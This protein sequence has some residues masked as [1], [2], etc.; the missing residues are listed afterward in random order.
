MKE[1]LY[2]PFLQWEVTSECNH[3]CIHCYNYWRK[4]SE[5]NHDIGDHLS[6][7]KK[8]VE[9]HPVSVVITGGEPLLVFDSIKSSLKLL[10]E[11]GI[12]LSI[13][14]NAVLV[15]DEIAEFLS[16]M[17]VS[18]LVS[19]PCSVPS[20]C[21]EI[22]N[23]PGSLDRIAKG[24]KILLK[25]NIKV[26]VNMVVSKKNVKYIYDTAKY[27]KEVLGISR[28]F[29]SRV[30]KPINSDKEFIKELLSKEEVIFIY[31]ELIRISKELKLTTDSSTPMPA[32][33]AMNEEIFNRFAYSRNCS[34]GKTS[35]GLDCLGNIKA[36]PR[37]I[38]IYG[39]ILTDDFSEVWSKMAEWR[40][41]KFVPKECK[42]CNVKNLCNGGCRL[43]AFPITGRRDSLDPLVCLE[44][45]PIKFTKKGTKKDFP[46][47]QVFIIPEN[48]QFI[49]EKFG[50]RVSV[51]RGFLVITDEMK[52]FLSSCTK[53]CI[54]DFIN[55]FDVEY[56]L[57]NNAVNLLFAKGIISICE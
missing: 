50:W 24:I 14:T 1:L 52:D 55:E 22:T 33:L 8:I 35:Y 23:I 45:I 19:L 57:A 27:S 26:T 36:C 3:N 12:S 5:K 4:D 48:I 44:N 13:N 20:I 17:D 37:D 42:T 6:I 10:K 11:N 30:S 56:S 31:E 2:P 25:H 34:A 16:E 47:E 49:K 43:D 9:R 46:K 40:E 38:E 28:F 32:C 7:A 51:G 18:A 53:F 54:N 15:T 41:G 39:N 29:A 21:D